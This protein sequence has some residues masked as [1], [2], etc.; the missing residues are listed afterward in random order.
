MVCNPAEHLHLIKDI[1]CWN[2]SEIYE[3]EDVVW[4]LRLTAGFIFGKLKITPVQPK[5]GR[6]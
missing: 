4:R 1:N 3:H 6:F 5:P 2:K